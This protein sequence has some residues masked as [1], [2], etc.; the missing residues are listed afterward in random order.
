MSYS[1]F[2][3][4]EKALEEI[5]PNL[6]IFNGRDYNKY[7]SSVALVYL[8]LL[9]SQTYN[10]YSISV[11]NCFNDLELPENFKLYYSNALHGYFDKEL[12]SF[13][14]V[15]VEEMKEYI[16]AAESYLSQEYMKTPW[17]VCSLANLIL[18]LSDEDNVGNPC[19]GDGTYIFNT[20]KNYDVKSL[21][22]TDINL[23]RNAM[24]EMMA[25][26]QGLKVSVKT[27]NWFDYISDENLPT[28][29][30]KLFSMIPWG[31]NLN[32]DMQEFADL[33]SFKCP[34]SDGQPL[35]ILSALDHLSNNGKAV[36]CVSNS[37]LINT[38]SSIQ[39]YLIDNGYLEAVVQLPANLLNVT[40]IP[41]S[42]FVLSHNNK[43]V[44]FINAS[45]IYSTT[46]RGKNELSVENIST[47]FE[48]YSS[49][50]KYSISVPCERISEN[51]YKLLPAEYL[52][53]PRLNYKGIT[54]YE[55]LENICISPITRGVQFKAEDLDTNDTSI[56]TDFYYL[57]VAGIKGNE[58]SNDIPNLLEIDDK[59]MSLCLKEDDVVI[60]MPISTT[61]KV[62]VAKNIKSKK[63]IP[64]SNLYIIRP[65]LS[66]I[67]SIFLKMLLESKTALDL[68]YTFNQG[69]M[70]SVDFLKGLEIPLPSLQ[71]QRL[72]AEKYCKVKL[73]ISEL[74]NAI[75]LLEKEQANNM[76]NSLE[77]IQ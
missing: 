57:N 26:V 45:N 46:R 49:D 19:C 11:Q 1:R 23:M 32:H 54:E 33:K 67:D 17:G 28:K 38:Q 30:K 42:L 36:I 53:K 60:S 51:E 35:Y 8:A 22:G 70:L 64:A 75:T 76:E 18:D 3:Y 77:D 55:K 9:V 15:P 27:E 6:L 52:F 12:T 50:S 74:K 61:P 31:I 59:A 40:A 72:I 62:A 21:E 2:H 39:K 69:M 68:I 7:V 71:E 5:D 63:I 34:R 41:F 25:E 58:I 44:R 24:I 66:K 4:V 48:M 14:G 37:M 20:I 13:R 29:Y 56:P 16:A 73:Q 65:D 43:T 10:D 47:I